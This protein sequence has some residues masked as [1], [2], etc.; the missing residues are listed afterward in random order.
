M[1]RKL[2]KHGEARSS[3]RFA[4]LPVRTDDGYF[5][6]LEWHTKVERYCTHYNR[7]LVYSRLY[8]EKQND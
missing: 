5:I 8:K 3:R 2:P 1:I 6:W 4:L 7:W